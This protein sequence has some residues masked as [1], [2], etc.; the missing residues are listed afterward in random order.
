MYVSSAASTV[1]TTSA[2]FGWPWP[3]LAHR[4]AKNVAVAPRLYG[5]SGPKKVL[6]PAQPCRPRGA[7]RLIPSGASALIVSW[8]A[9]QDEP[10][11]P[12]TTAPSSASRILPPGLRTAARSHSV[13]PPVASR[14]P[15]VT[16]YPAASSEAATS[17]VT[18]A[19]A[20]S[21][22]AS[23]V[24]FA[25]ERSMSTSHRST[26][27]C[28]SATDRTFPS[29]TEQLTFATLSETSVAPSAARSAAPPR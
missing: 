18:A 2:L 3:A 19:T 10:S 27:V 1:A 17:A 5:R 21:P 14:P 15:L 20:A 24:S 16:G 4:T 6:N 11:S 25:S 8:T 12:P 22:A 9:Q 26:A 23:T 7:S 28:A 13:P 29:H